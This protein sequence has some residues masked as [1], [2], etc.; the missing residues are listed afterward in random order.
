VIERYKSR[1]CV[2]V[3]KLDEYKQKTERKMKSV[4]G[5]KRKKESEEGK[6]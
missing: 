2:S 1:E 3:T 5:R 6:K 4:R